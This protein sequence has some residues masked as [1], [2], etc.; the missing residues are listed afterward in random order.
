MFPGRAND[1]QSPAPVIEQALQVLPQRRRLQIWLGLAFRRL[2]SEGAE[3]FIE[4][5]KAPFEPLPLNSHGLANPI[6][7]LAASCLRCTQVTVAI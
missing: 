5:V 3:I 1:S 2:I 6:P 4:P 7:S